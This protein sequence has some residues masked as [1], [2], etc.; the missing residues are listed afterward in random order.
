MADSDK[1]LP[2]CSVPWTEIYT[3]NTG[4]MIECCGTKPNI[5]AKLGQSIDD[6]W[7]SKEL[8]EFRKK[9]MGDKLPNACY[10]CTMAELVD[11]KSLRTETNKQVNLQTSELKYPSRWS[12]TFGSV[13]NLGC[14]IC[15]EYSSTVIENHKRKL[16]ML[17]IGFVS[18]QQTFKQQWPRL[19]KSILKSYDHHD[20]VNINIMGGEPLY[21]KDVIAFLEKL[22]SLGLS[23][24]TKL[25]FHTNATQSSARIQKILGD[26]KVYKTWKHISMFLSLD[27]VGK[28][29]EWLRWGCDWN[30]IEQNV[31]MFKKFGV[32][33]EVHCTISILNVGDV[34][35]MKDW[36]DSIGLPVAYNIIDNP[37]FMTL[38]H[39][40]GDPDLLCDR[41]K[42]AQ[43]SLA[44]YYDRIGTKKDSDAPMKLKQYVEKLSTLR[45]SL[46]LYDEK[47]AD[48]FNID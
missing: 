32:W 45:K 48:I 27:T 47:L 31:T 24:R 33:L 37:E 14:F 4:H 21:N 28:K 5:K 30:K 39:W 42:M 40:P 36:C 38:E 8:Q 22:V 26:Y 10:T 12:V 35:D 19:E 6:W 13:C 34:T 23:K 2:L 46:R 17:P 16:Q 3:R 18:P 43:Y 20:T 41:K 15:E 9:L 11:G 1:K 7:T 44:H 25:E 29:A